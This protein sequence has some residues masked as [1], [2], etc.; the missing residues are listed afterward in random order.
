MNRQFM[1]ASNLRTTLIQAARN[2]PPSD[3]V[4]YAFEK[5]ILARLAGMQPLDSWALWG[6]A[7]WRAAAVCLVLMASLCLGTSLLRPSPQMQQAAVP[8]TLQQLEQTLVA[9]VDREFEESW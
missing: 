2:H 4:P 3:A 1:K 6:A 9:S 7:L 8:E 5:R